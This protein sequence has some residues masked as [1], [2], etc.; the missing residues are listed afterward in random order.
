MF[1]F[2]AIKKIIAGVLKAVYRLLCVFNLQF[3]ILVALVGILLWALGVFEDGGFPLILFVVVFIGSILLAIIL[4]VRKI[5]GL[6][7][8]KQQKS[9]VQIVKKQKQDNETQSMPVVNSSE[10]PNVEN[11]SQS[12]TANM[13]QEQYNSPPSDVQEKPRYYRV[14]QNSNYV[15][16]EYSNRYELYLIT[17]NGLKKIRTDY[18]Q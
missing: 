16:A 6:D 7:N 2:R 18:K 9:N 17:P 14:K 13:A 10:I 8:K 4:T 5:L 3:S 12:Y 15:M 1:I 11:A